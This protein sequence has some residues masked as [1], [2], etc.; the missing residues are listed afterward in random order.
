MSKSGHMS[1]FQR[2]QWQLPLDTSRT[3][4]G[5]P[6]RCHQSDSTLLPKSIGSINI[7]DD[8]KNRQ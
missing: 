6:P 3:L 2:V 1:A 4:I 8:A 5:K 7:H